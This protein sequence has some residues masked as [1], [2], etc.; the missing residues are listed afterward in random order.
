MPFIRGT[1]TEGKQHWLQESGYWGERISA[2]NWSPYQAQ[3]ECEKIRLRNIQYLP[4]P[5]A[6]IPEIIDVS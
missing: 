2:K 5:D 1:D 4:N 6:I 3:I